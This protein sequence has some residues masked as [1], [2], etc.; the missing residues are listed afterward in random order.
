MGE[1]EEGLLPSPPS[2]S[3]VRASSIET[4][5]PLPE[6]VTLDTVAPGVGDW[7][8]SSDLAFTLKRNL[9]YTGKWAS[10]QWPYPPMDLMPSTVYAAMATEAFTEHTKTPYVS[11]DDQLRL[12]PAAEFH[13]LSIF[14]D[15]IEQQFNRH[16]AWRKGGFVVGVNAAHTH[17]V[18]VVTLDQV[19]WRII[20]TPIWFPYC[21]DRGWEFDGSRSGQ[22]AFRTAM[23]SA[24]DWDGKA[25]TEPLH[26]TR[27]LGLT[28]EL[29][30]KDQ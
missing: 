23:I 27:R 16:I 5:I 15:R 8:L 3:I 2:P 14:V 18:D 19:S 28:G 20:E 13:W 12:L 21:F 24:V 29:K 4:C 11:P 9:I 7:V 10:G 25:D 30:G 6:P 17:Y 22:W 1:A 26:Y